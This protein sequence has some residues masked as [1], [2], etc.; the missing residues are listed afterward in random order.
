MISHSMRFRR[1]GPAA[2]SGGHHPPSLQLQPLRTAHRSS[3]ITS[4]RY[5]SHTTRLQCSPYPY[6]PSAGND[7][8]PDAAG[9][10]AGV[11]RH[12]QAFRSNSP[13]TEQQQQ[14]HNAPPRKPAGGGGGGSGSNGG[15][16]A[17]VAADAAASGAPAAPSGCP[18]H[19]V[20]DPTP[21]GVTEVAAA[22]AAVLPAAGAS[23]DSGSSSKRKGPSSAASSVT[24]LSGPGGC[25][26]VLPHG[27]VDG[28]SDRGVVWCASVV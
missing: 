8:T 22:A 17:S 2:K 24:H 26:K 27:N 21:A 23:N 1:P 14:Q 11:S 25:W 4:R 9:V 15:S 28:V 6:Q 16:S 19:Q 5:H 20:Q 10:S 18:F 13:D 7:G 3:T 12:A